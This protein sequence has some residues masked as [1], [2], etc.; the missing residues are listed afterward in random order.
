MTGGG[1]YRSRGR[2]CWLAAYQRHSGDSSVD[3]LC[4]H[5]MG[6]SEVLKEKTFVWMR[7]N[8]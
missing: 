6:E 1:E 2:A 5:V 7:V 4:S 8:I 3:R